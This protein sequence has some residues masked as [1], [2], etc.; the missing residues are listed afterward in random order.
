MFQDVLVITFGESHRVEVVRLHELV[1]EVGTEHHRLGGGDREIGVVVQL[2]VGLHHVADKGET[3]PFSSQR[4]LADAG[5]VG[6]LVEPFLLEDRHNTGV[7]HPTVLN[8]GGMDQLTGIVH[9]GILR[10]IDLL[11]HL[12]HGEHGP[13]VEEA[14]E[15]VS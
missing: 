9:A 13:G 1:E 4:P 2:Q 15:V 10:D 8:D 11:Q 12:S 7:F 14:G 3:S 6:V 5:E